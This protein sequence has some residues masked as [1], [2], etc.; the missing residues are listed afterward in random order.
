MLAR[1][2]RTQV[3]EK[4]RVNEVRVKVMLMLSRGQRDALLGVAI[5][6][7]KV[8]DGRGRVSISEVVRAL[9]DA[10]IAAGAEVPCSVTNNE[11]SDCGVQANSQ[12]VRR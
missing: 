1:R 12:K 8:R 9:L 3:M 5:K 4:S 7:R 11:G 6:L 2:A 10:W